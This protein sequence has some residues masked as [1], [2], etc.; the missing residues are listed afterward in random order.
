[1]V[2][3]T[4]DLSADFHVWGCEFTPADVVYF[5]DGAEVQR[6]SA[7]AMAHGDQNIWLTTIAASMGSTD[8][9]DDARLPSEFTVDWV[10]FYS[11]E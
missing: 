7:S 2:V 10:R 4:P 3:R 8:A 6:V 9:V 5:F 11:K 1:M